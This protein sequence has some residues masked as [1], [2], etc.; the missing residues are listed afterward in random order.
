[1]GE[2]DFFLGFQRG[3]HWDFMEFEWDLKGHDAT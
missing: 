3:I 2:L 1:M